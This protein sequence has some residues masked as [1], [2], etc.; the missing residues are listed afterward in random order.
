MAEG[1]IGQETKDVAVVQGPRPVVSFGNGKGLEPKDLDGAWRCAQLVA[2]SGLAP[3]GIQTPEAV[4]VA[5]AMGAEIGLSFMQ[6]LQNIAVINGRPSVWGDAALALVRASGLCDEYRESVEGQGDAMTA[7]AFGRRKGEPQGQEERFG[8]EDAKRAGLWNKEGPWKQYPRRMLTMRAR[9]FLLRNLWPDVLKGT[10]TAEEA[11]DIPQFAATGPGTSF[12]VLDVPE[13]KPTQP[14]PSMPVADT[15]PE[16]KQDEEKPK[17][18]RKEKTAA[19]APT[20]EDPIPL[21]PIEGPFA[22]GEIVTHE[23]HGAVSVLSWHEGPNGLQARVKG[24]PG[25]A[26]ADAEFYAYPGALKSQPVVTATPEAPADTI[27]CAGP[28]RGDRMDVKYCKTSCTEKGQCGELA[29]FLGA[30]PAKP[31]LFG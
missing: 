5:A 27:E 1:T 23:K 25:S 20:D 3:K 22:V 17:R 2:K 24:E 11:G 13:E 21:P 8:V 16:P 31:G 12:D 15:A 18:T 7:I 30:T 29:A 6:S 19:P 14:A 4:L 10:I 26:F 28:N 9:G